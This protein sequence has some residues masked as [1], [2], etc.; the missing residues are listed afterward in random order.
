MKRD[1]IYL[2]IVG[3]ILSSCFSD[4]KTYN[5][6][7]D[8]K[9]KSEANVLHVD[10]IDFFE[11]LI[12]ASD[13]WVY[14]DSILIVRNKKHTDG[15][16]LEFYDLKSR[17]FLKR[18]FRLGNG[19]N[20]L[21]SARI[22]INKNELTAIDYIKDQVVCINIDSVIHNPD[23][24]VSPKRYFPHSPGA[25][26]HTD[27]NILVE[28]PHC[29]KDDKLRIDNKAPRFILN[30]KDN[31]FYDEKT[32]RYN[33]WNVATSGSII[34]NYRKDRVIYA[35]SHLPLIEVYDASLNLHK[36]IQGPDDLPPDYRIVSDEFATN[37]I[38]FKK[39]YIPFSYLDFCT[40][41][42]FFCLVYMGDYLDLVE[43]RNMEDYPMWI[44]Q[45]DW[46]GNFIDSYSVGRYITSLS[47]SADG[48][49]FYATAINSEK[50]PFLIKLSIK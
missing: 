50:N 14:Q 12:Y 29:F 33:T 1:Y 15:Y 7:L 28:N 44:F 45:F 3:C 6:S 41:N 16:F 8:K 43:Q 25:V 32:Y 17:K 42:D 27:G 36:T 31:A 39:G 37:E 2:V 11:E 34:T 30:K 5:Y 47:L 22:T 10:T 46:D 49:S 35:A 18:L 19:P 40:N 21:L 48:K 24:M 23:Y 9:I 26:Q 20:E 13:F 38:L 4:E